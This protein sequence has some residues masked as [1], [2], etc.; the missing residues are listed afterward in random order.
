LNGDPIANL[1]HKLKLDTNEIQ[2]RLGPF[3]LDAPASPFYADDSDTT[4]DEEEEVG[5]EVGL[6]L[7]FSDARLCSG[8]PPLCSPAHSLSISLTLTLDLFAPSD[9]PHTHTLSLSLC[10]SLCL[11]L[12]S[13]TFW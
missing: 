9:L 5:S 13:L 7:C 1:I 3:G 2:L 10:L 6:K 4:S 8:R 12:G 11:S